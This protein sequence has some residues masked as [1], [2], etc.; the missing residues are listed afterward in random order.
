MH[1][2]KYRLL[3]DV[4]SAHSYI[5]YSIGHTDILCFW[6]FVGYFIYFVTVNKLAK[7]KLIEPGIPVVDE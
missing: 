4:H 1:S 7:I 3:L 6:I 5:D 2:D